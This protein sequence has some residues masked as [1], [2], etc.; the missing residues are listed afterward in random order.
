MK[1]LVVIHHSFT[2]DSDTIS[3]GAIRKYHVEKNGWRDI[4]YHY[5]VEL[6]GGYYEIFVGRPEGEVAAAVKEGNVNADGVHICVVGN[7]DKA[8]PPKKQLEAVARLVTD[9]CR[10]N[11]IGTRAITTHHQFAPYKSCPGEKFPMAK[12]VA[13][14][15]ENLS[16]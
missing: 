3:W 6:V 1:S 4:G 14:V 7:F 11:G 10:R 12:L 9:I 2:D 5:G 13:L 15:Q 16:Q 8:P